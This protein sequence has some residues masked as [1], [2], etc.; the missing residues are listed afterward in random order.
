MAR[1][2]LDYPRMIA[3]ALRGVARQALEQVSL[4]GLPGDHH[5]YLSFHTRAD[6]VRIPPFLRDQYPDEMTVVLQNQFSDLVVDHEAFSVTLTFG[7]SRH[8]IY[9]PFGALTAFTDPTAQV[10]LRFE[11]MEVDGEE[12][13]GE[14]TAEEPGEQTGGDTD[15]AEAG[16][17]GRVVDF[18][19]FR[20]KD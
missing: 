13:A 20:K 17:P 11:P 7:G 4:E 10:G 3:E 8:S 14:E 1:Q 15:A 18:D 12:D 2:H 6:G 5:F 19:R 9:V 16:P